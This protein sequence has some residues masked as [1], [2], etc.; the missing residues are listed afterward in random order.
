MVLFG[1]DISG[2]SLEER[3]LGIAWKKRNTRQGTKHLRRLRVKQLVSA[4]Q[5]KIMRGR[6]EMS[7]I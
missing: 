2:K 5:W 4:I 3:G 7:V 6:F 1:S